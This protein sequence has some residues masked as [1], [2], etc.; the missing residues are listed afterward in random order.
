MFWAFGNLTSSFEQGMML[1]TVKSERYIQKSE[2]ADTKSS[3]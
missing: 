2:L 3:L 1:G